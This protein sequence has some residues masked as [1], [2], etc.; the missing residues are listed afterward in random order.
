[1]NPKIEHGKES[2]AVTIP[3]SAAAPAAVLRALALNL[4]ALCSRVFQ[5]TDADDEASS[6]APGAGAL[7]TLFSP[8]FQFIDL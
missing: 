7:P 1:M 2:D 3:G 6:A 4:R 5:S 8:S